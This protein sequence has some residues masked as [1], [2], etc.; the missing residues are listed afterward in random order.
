MVFKTEGDIYKHLYDPS[1]ENP[2]KC[3]RETL[4]VWIRATIR[5]AI[6]EGIILG[7]KRENKR[8]ADIIKNTRPL[9]SDIQKKFDIALKVW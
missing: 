4:C 1:I 8:I 3:S 9:A 6:N 2:G 5:L 7:T